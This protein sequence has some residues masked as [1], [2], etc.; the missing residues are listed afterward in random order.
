MTERYVSS[1]LKRIYDEYAYLRYEFNENFFIRVYVMFCIFFAGHIFGMKP[2]Q[3]TCVPIL[4]ILY[5]VTAQDT[6][7]QYT[8]SPQYTPGGSQYN[9]YN[10]N[11]PSS[12]SN[13]N[14]DINSYNPY[15]QEP[16]YGQN[17][18]YGQNDLNSQNVPYGQSNPTG[19]S[20]YG[21]IDP[22]G[23][24]NRDRGGLYDH[25]EDLNGPWRSPSYTGGGTSPFD[26][27]S[28][29]IREA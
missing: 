16:Q 20:P 23:I 14:G 3:L 12:T 7:P 13:P 8:P 2:R 24:G 18:P 6:N 1:A 9:K 21:N 17:N 22:N 11:Y 25:D 29:I 28:T 5:C 19:Q 26:S 27:H 15:T 10:F 4:L